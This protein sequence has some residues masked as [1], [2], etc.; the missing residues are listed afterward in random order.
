MRLVF[1]ALAGMALGTICAAAIAPFLW[2]LKSSR[3]RIAD[4]TT[5][6]AVILVVFLDSQVCAE[7]PDQMVLWSN[8]GPPRALRQRPCFAHFVGVRLLPS[9]FPAQE[10]K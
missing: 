9:L 2:L 10:K 7:D 1:A 6:A 5:K 8:H 4:W 3:A